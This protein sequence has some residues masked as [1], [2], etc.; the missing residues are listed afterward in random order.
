MTAQ[1]VSSVGEST[2]VVWPEP[3]Y[4]VSNFLASFQVSPFNALPLECTGNYTYFDTVLGSTL[5]YVLL[6]IA[7]AIFRGLRDMHFSGYRKG[8]L[9]EM[10]PWG[11]NGP[12]LKLVVYLAYVVLPSSSR[13]LFKF[14]ICQDFEDGTSW[15]KADYQIE[16]GTPAYRAQTIYV[17]IM[18]II[19][20]IGIPLT[21]LTLLRRN[22]QEIENLP[23]DFV[24]DKKLTKLLSDKAKPLK[25]LFA[26][27]TP[28][29]WHAEVI[30]STR[31]LVLDGVVAIICGTRR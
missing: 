30:E 3:F 25:F 5:M 7:I 31:R 29:N 23:T 1:L 16:C 11:L 26:S 19:F 22:R 28:A 18:I 9:V 15:L 27:Y 20:P 2:G 12:E 4:S 8:S 10:T 24:S 17:M 21:F 13:V 14:L 6:M